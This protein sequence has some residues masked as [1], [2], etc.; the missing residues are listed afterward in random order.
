MYCYAVETKRIL[1][2]PILLGLTGVMMIM[3]GCLWKWLPPGIGGSIILWFAVY[4][5]WHRTWE[6]GDFVSFA[7]SYL[8]ITRR[9][10]QYL[11]HASEIKEVIYGNQT[12]LKLQ[13]AW[14]DLG[15]FARCKHFQND[16]VQFA[17]YN[18]IYVHA[19][20][21]KGQEH[22]KYARLRIVKR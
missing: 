19:A 12:K 20:G 9:K 4:V 13:Q 14:F 5:Y 3:A 17:V 6:P 18:K 22:G 7:E 10:K 16:L 1:L 21:S 8:L 2:F 15:C 11:F